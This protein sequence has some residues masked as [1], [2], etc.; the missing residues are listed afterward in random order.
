[1]PTTHKCECK[2][3]FTTSGGLKVHRK[4]CLVYLSMLKGIE[5]AQAPDTAPAPPL[6]KTAGTA[7][8][9]SG[10]QGAKAGRTSGARFR[11]SRRGT[12]IPQAYID[13][14]PPAPPLADSSK[15]V[16]IQGPVTTNH[17]QT[18]SN[19]FGV[20]RLYHGALPTFNPDANF[21]L[22]ATAD[23]PNFDH[24]PI[25]TLPPAPGPYAEPQILP[26]SA[27]PSNDS[28]YPNKTIELIMSWFYTSSNTKS[29]N[30]LN[31][32]IHNV[33]LSPDFN[34]RHLQDFDA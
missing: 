29:L 12:S 33:L 27:A 3:S 18:P 26:D 7:S 32:L 11:L 24:T 15:S 16:P 31:I 20:H 13:E 4:K 1:M 28:P 30:D 34:K 9:T 8:S 19:H 17:S 22:N 23:H 10:T 14:L 2:Q 21:E 5:R 25:T 6:P